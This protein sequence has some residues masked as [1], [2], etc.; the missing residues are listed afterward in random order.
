MWTRF[1][2]FAGVPALAVA[3]LVA[4]TTYVVSGTQSTTSL[5]SFPDDP[6]T[7]TVDGHKALAKKI[8]E[9]R[10]KSKY[11]PLPWVGTKLTR[12]SCP[13]GLKAAT[14]TT[15]TCTGEADGRT[16]SIP[17]TV[18]KTEGSKI[19]WKFDR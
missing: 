13:T 5:G 18:I 2:A 14:G 16:I 17:V 12:V 9:G 3:T 7:V 8:I 1:V 4:V 6:A 19:T 11:H 10:T 15:M